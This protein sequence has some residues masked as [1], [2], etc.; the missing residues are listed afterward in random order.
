MLLY[1]YLIVVF[2]KKNNN[3]IATKKL[4]TTELNYKD[5]HNN[6]YDNGLVFLEKDHVYAND[7]DLFGENS[8]FHFIN[9]CF[10]SY[11]CKCLANWLMNSAA[12]DEILERQAS[13]SELSI[14]ISFRTKIGIIGI[15]SR[16]NQKINKVTEWL[17]N[18]K[19]LKV[20]KSLSKITFYFSLINISLI[21]LSLFNGLLI[22]IFILFLLF[23]YLY[24]YSYKWSKVKLL[25]DSIS[26]TDSDLKYYSNFL[27]IIEDEKF[28]SPLL[29][30]LKEELKINNITVTK[31]IKSLQNL[32]KWTDYRL[33]F[34]F[35]LSINTLFYTDIW[36]LLR[37]EKWK[38]QFGSQLVNWQNTIGQLEALVSFS[39]LHFNNPDWCVPTIEKEYHVQ[40][41]EAGHPLIPEND[42]I[43]NSYE[44]DKLG[45]VDIIT[46]SNMSGKSTF[47][48]TIGV[49]IVLA[50][51][52][53]NV[54]CKKM[55]ISPL[56]L[57]T[58]MRIVDNMQDNTST[59][60][61]E[62]KRLK[63]I[64]EVSHNNEYVFLLLDELLRGTNSKD[65]TSG[66]IA[67]IK[68]IINNNSNAIIAT[69]DLSITN[70]SQENYSN[71]RNFYFDISITEKK[72]HFDYKIKTGVCQSTN[73]S[74]LLKEIGIE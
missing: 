53:A 60:Y 72:M 10:S 64:L 40:L 39:I 7:L 62:I 52:G 50:Q 48:R 22:P 74:L 55:K 21:I 57:M 8:I 9:R 36:L 66:S 46:G 61:A 44:I 12:S 49:N 16:D 14:N 18:T 54:C 24:I 42:R 63:N 19:S 23:S 20:L 56:K 6:L 2:K 29:N 43:T 31:T 3:L 32:I 71:I 4:F 45:C 5:L 34:F 28:T 51:A 30:K 38:M 11:G 26:K 37:I 73:A 1:Y 41:L 67:I 17:G 70:I 69:H 13:I 59:F 35:Q 27:T 68:N 33:N 47:L 65:K 15:Q 58:Y 25:Y